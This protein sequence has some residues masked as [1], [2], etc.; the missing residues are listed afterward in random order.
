MKNTGAFYKPDNTCTFCVWAPEKEQVTLHLITPDDRSMAMTKDAEG[1]F[2]ITVENVPPG[3]TYFYNID[4]KDLPDPASG[5]QPQ[6][7]FGPSAVVDHDAYQWQ[8]LQWHGLPFKDLI[9]YE[10]HVGTFS[11][12]GTFEGIIPYLDDLK[13][14][15]INA[16]ELMPVCQFP[17]ERNWGYDGVY[18]YAVHHSYGGPEGLKKLVDAC[19][20]RGIAVLLDVVYNHLGGGRQLF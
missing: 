19:H 4:E 15:G 12:E 18:Q 2:T 13:E 8:D 11:P 9:L 14:T 20:Q 17:G 3:A 6:D 16:L 10:L 7:I 5:W 1:Y